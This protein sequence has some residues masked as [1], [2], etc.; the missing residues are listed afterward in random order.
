MAEK[1]IVIGL[2]E[3]NLAVI[4]MT[5]Q[6]ACAKCKACLAG[7]SEKDMFVEAEN[8]CGAQ[9]DDWV[10]IELAPDGFIHAVL[11]MYG[12]PFLAFMAGIGVGYALG[13]MQ[14]FVNREI[15]SC[16]VGLLFTFAAFMWIRSQEKRWSTK[17]Y[18]P[19]A[20]RLA[21]HEN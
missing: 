15:V 19:V 18:R 2:K 16:A 8:A 14:A 11:I 6:E 7:M 12:I 13:G 20:A 9:V 4:K 1:G 10:E 17:K 5:R 3:N 21:T